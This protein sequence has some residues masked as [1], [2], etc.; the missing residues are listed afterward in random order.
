MTEN[1]Y[2]RLKRRQ[3]SIAGQLRKL[4][5]NTLEEEKS[6]ASVQK[7]IADLLMAVKKR[8]AERD[9]RQR[10]RLNGV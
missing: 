1:E 6:F 7:A 2:K 5:A 4:A 10:P 3:D 9:S 8:I